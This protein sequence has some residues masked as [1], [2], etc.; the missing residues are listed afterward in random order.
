[1]QVDTSLALLACAVGRVL[2]IHRNLQAVDRPLV[3][4]DHFLWCFG[5]ITFRQA[6]VRMMVS[7]ITSNTSHLL[8]KCQYR[9]A[10]GI[11]GMT[12]TRTVQT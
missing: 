3:V 12:H 5:K 9:L 1:V 8:P 10:C 2:L 7:M 4:P 11:H 6:A